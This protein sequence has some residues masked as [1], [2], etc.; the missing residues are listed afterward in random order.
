L[1]NKPDK[2]VAV[3]VFTD[4]YLEHHIQWNVG[5]PTL[6]VLPESG[7]NTNFSPPAGKVVSM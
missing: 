7:S 5:K 3:I 6:W 4:G 2:P 1:S